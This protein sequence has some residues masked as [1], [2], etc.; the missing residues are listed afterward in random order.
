MHDP[1]NDDAL[2][3]EMDGIELPE[4]EYELTPKSMDTIDRILN[5]CDEYERGEKSTQN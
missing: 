3:R 4:I 5:A 2:S 1:L